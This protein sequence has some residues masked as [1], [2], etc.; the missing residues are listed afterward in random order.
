MVIPLKQ[1]QLSKKVGSHAMTVIVWHLGWADISALKHL[2]S[3]AGF[4]GVLPPEEHIIRLP[5]LFRHKLNLPQGGICALEFL[6]SGFFPVH[7]L[8]LTP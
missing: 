3:Q 2:L 5:F 1:L 6:F 4:H 8:T 7:P